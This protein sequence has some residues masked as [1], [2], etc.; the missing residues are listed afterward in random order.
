VVIVAEQLR[1]TVPGGIGTYVRGLVKGLDAMGD[2]GPAV[3]LWA[4]RAP[5]GRPDPLAALGLTVT[6]PLTGPALVGAWDRGWAGFGSWPGSGGTATSGG[7]VDVVHAPSLAVPPR[8]GAPVAVTVHD[9]A[10]RQVPEAFPAR[11]RR[12][13]EAALGRALD[14]ASLFVVPSRT[15][16]DALVEAGAGPA[17]VEVVDEGSDHLPAPDP[18]A[19]GA[20]LAGLGVTGPFLLSVGTLE[21]RKNLSR[22]VAAYRLARPRL[23]EP[24]PLVVVGPQGWGSGPAADAD[25]ATDG[26]QD[27]E[28]VVLAGWV[29]DAVLASLY[30]QA[31]A[32]AYVPLLEGFGLPA[33]E[34]MAAGTPVVASP[35]PSLGGAALEVDPCDVGAIADAL[36]VAATD[37]A[38]RSE[39]AAAGGRRAASLTWQATA[40]AHVELWRSLGA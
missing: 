6:S 29:D 18:V 8:R 37:D 2:A 11:G 19:A 32:L 34:A 21:P 13:H 10:W 16:A 15:T 36:V 33:L 1:R 30:R 40:R 31:R 22:L 12:W 26:N 20:V 23:P 27:H 9:L 38:V 24:W 35:M 28:G 5:R 7:D 39:L 3:A 17:Q 25:G 4:S 14:R